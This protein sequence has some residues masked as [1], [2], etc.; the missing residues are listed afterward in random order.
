LEVYSVTAVPISL[1]LGKERDRKK[2]ERQ[3]VE[4]WRRK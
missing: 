2:K 4:E 3:D 1:L